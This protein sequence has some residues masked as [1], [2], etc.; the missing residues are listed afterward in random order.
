[1][2]LENAAAS[3]Q[4][5]ARPRRKAP[6]LRALLVETAALAVALSRV[7]PKEENAVIRRW[8]TIRRNPS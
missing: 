4:K 2:T 5:K 1:M 8:L 7:P 6:R 3:G